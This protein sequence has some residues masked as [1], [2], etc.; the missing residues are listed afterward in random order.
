ML[1]GIYEIEEY[2]SST[3]TDIIHLES[4][5]SLKLSNAEWV[6]LLAAKAD[7]DGCELDKAAGESGDAWKI[8]VVGAKNVA[9][10]CKESGKKLLYVST[11]FVFDGEKEE[12]ES[13]SEDDT[14]N[15]VN[16]YAHTKW[17]GE[18]AVKTS[19]AEF[20]I[21]RLAYPYRAS[22]DTKN[23]FMRAIKTRLENGQPI[24]GVTDHLFCPTFIDD[25]VTACDILIQHNSEGIYHVTG[26]ETLTPYEAAQIIADTFDLNSELISGTTRAEYFAGKAERPFNLSLNNGK[27]KALGVEMKTF[28][29]GLREIKSQLE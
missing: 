14:P 23:D 7:V 13:Y 6:I 4:L 24:A 2:N 22:F 25:F 5:N 12:G 26:S 20:V 9:D 21:V 18:E 28:G 10:V 29:E 11:D 15:P 16:W 8:N 17:Q 3:G 19:G 1:K 27:I